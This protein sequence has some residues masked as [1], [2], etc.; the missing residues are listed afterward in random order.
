[1]EIKRN[2]FIIPLI[3]I[4][5]ALLGSYFS[6]GGMSWYDTT[7]IKPELTPPKWLFPVAWNLIFLFTTI[8]ALIVWNKGKE[9]TQFLWVLTNEKESN[10][11]WLIV[12]LFIANAVL[13]VL[14]SFF[15]FELQLI[16]IAFVEMLFLE[17]TL[18]VL[19]PLIWH[20]SKTAS[21]LLLPYA[22]W[23]AFATYLTFQIVRLN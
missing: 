16:E 19:I 12:W 17:A 7:L 15:F 8:S 23:V 22:L 18:L 6:T 3:T 4:F 9:K 21:L 13:N 14:W 11:Y 2:Y 10:K 5:V 20:I 1:M